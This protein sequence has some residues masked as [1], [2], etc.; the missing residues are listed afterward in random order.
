MHLKIS[1]AKCQP[2]CLG[3]HVAPNVLFQRIA[4]EL[5]ALEQDHESVKNKWE[6]SKAR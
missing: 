6:A 1:S 4:K 5:K 3:V 2:L